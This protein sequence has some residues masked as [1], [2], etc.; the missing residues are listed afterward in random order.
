MIRNKTTQNKSNQVETKRN[1]TTRTK[2]KLFETHR[3]ETK[4]LSSERVET[5]AAIRNETG[6]HR[7]PGSG[8]QGTLVLMA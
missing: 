8:G 6:Q 5:N 1:T 4:Q 3:N 7:R 2:S